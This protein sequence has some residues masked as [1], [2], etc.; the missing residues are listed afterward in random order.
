MGDEWNSCAGIDYGEKWCHMNKEIPIRISTQRVSGMALPFSEEHGI[1]D[2][3][4]NDNDSDNE[5]DML[6]MWY[7]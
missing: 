1:N 5:D 3:D 2:H 7:W 6:R 4:D